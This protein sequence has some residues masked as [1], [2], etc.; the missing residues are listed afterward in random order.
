MTWK[1]EDFSNDKKGYL[2]LTQNGIRVCDFFPFAKD[3]SPD[4]VKAQAAYICQ[5][6]NEDVGAETARCAEIA[7]SMGDAHI[8]EAIEMGA[9]MCPTRIMT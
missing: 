5:I 6:L 9:M 7:R 8:A 1:I 2:Q 4:I 3:A